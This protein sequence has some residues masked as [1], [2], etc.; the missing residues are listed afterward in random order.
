MQRR[1]LVE[2]AVRRL[3][4]ARGIDRHYLL[5]VSGRVGVAT[6][7]RPRMVAAAQGAMPDLDSIQVCAIRREA[8]AQVDAVS[9]DRVEPSLHVGQRELPRRDDL[10]DAARV[11]RVGVEEDHHRAV[12]GGEAFA[13]GTH[14]SAARLA[15]LP[16]CRVKGVEGLLRPVRRSVIDDDCLQR[17]VVLPEDAADRGREE[18][19][20]VVIDCEDRH[21]RHGRSGCLRH[22]LSMAASARQDAICPGER[23]L[24][25]PGPATTFCSSSDRGSRPA[26]P[27]TASK[28]SRR[29]TSSRCRPARRQP[30][31]RVGSTARRCAT[32]TS[33]CSIN[34]QCMWFY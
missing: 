11:K 27:D 6:L 28:E 16:D 21:E 8:Q 23:R 33:N 34:L 22:G 14:M 25:C 3:E 2:V 29:Q 17:R 7:R 18:P 12:A 26:D 30:R 4:D 15:H 13:G 31:I 1:H 10:R 9:V 24:R 19:P 5:R 32:T 20:M